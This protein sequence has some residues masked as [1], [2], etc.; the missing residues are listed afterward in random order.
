[1]L[2]QPQESRNIQRYDKTMKNTHTTLTVRNKCIW[3]LR[4]GA[5]WPAW[6]APTDQF[7]RDNVFIS[8]SYKIPSFCSLLWNRN[9]S[10][11]WPRTARV[12][13]N[14]IWLRRPA[15]T[16]NHISPH[17]PLPKHTFSSPECVGVWRWGLSRWQHR[18]GFILSRHGYYNDNMGNLVRLR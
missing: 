17:T 8:P 5:C 15:T 11:I 18:Q 12:K 9:H 3:N 1:M 4:G 13:I 10:E 7:I 2:Q 16:G 6:K 14:N